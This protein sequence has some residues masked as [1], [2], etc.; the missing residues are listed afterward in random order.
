MSFYSTL[1][2]Q[3]FSLRTL[4]RLFPFFHYF[5]IMLFRKQM[6]YKHNKTLVSCEG[7]IVQWVWTFI[8]SF[9][10][11]SAPSLLN[12]WIRLTK[13]K[14]L[15]KFKTATQKVVLV[16]VQSKVIDVE[17]DITLIYTFQHCILCVFRLRRHFNSN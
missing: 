2:I 5:S 1:F 10:S 4:F 14:K 15:E 11:L 16:R 3:K 13:Y 17:T 6:M 12:S 9:Q 7:E 8:K